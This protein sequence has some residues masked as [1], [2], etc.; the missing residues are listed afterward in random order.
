MIKATTQQV[1][2]WIINHNAEITHTTRMA[3][4]GEEVQ[5]VKLS[6]VDNETLKSIVGPR[7][8]VTLELMID[9]AM[10]E[11]AYY[12]D[13]SEGTIETKQNVGRSSA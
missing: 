1:V 6:W 9:K 13:T 4:S 2:L 8:S 12:L 7:E 5:E 11:S 10:A 3:E